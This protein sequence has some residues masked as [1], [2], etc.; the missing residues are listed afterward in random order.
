MRIAYLVSMVL[1]AGIFVWTGSF[2][3]A[4]VFCALVLLGA[5]LLISVVLTRSLS[6]IRVKIPA[7]YTVGSHASMRLELTAGL[8]LRLSIFS[9]HLKCESLAFK[10]TTERSF[11]VAFSTQGPTA[12]PIPL[13]SDHY[14]RMHIAIE[15]AYCEDPL[16]LFRLAFPLKEQAPC[17]VH[18]QAVKLAVGVEHMPLSRSFGTTYDTTRSGSDVDEVFDIREFEA[19]DHLASIHWKLSTKFDEMISRQFSRP[20]DFEMV[21]IN[22]VS[23]A[24]REQNPINPALLNGA[25]SVSSTISS[26]LFGQ[27]LSHNYALPTNGMLQSIALD[28]PDSPDRMLELLLDAPV[29]DTYEEA[30]AALM[31]S[32]L[33]ENFTKCILVTPVY[34]DLLWS[35]LAYDMNLSVVFLSEDA[36]IAQSEGEYDVVTVNVSDL[37]DYERSIAL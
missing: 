7:S 4:G 1:I 15:H 34:D 25:A 30:C 20:V 13:D 6:T 29:P 16:G 23:L 8:P 14:G 28:G 26:D 22:F 32:E 10:T 11:R 31:V 36:D 17:I 33:A 5:M 2:V 21:V 27:G 3:A 9:F 24:D 35:Q 12:M 19:G 37:K 18:P